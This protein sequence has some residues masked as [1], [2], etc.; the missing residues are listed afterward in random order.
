VREVKA[1][2]EFS[3]SKWEDALADAV[4]RNDPEE[5]SKCRSGLRDGRTISEYRRN[6]SE[7]KP[8]E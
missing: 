7:K 2:A 6:W 1:A 5:A 8:V 3:V 4:R